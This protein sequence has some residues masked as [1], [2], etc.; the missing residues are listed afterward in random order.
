MSCSGHLFYLKSI[1]LRL[2]ALLSIW[3]F[4]SLPSFAL[5][6]P[7]DLTLSVPFRGKTNQEEQVIKMGSKYRAGQVLF[8]LEFRLGKPLFQEKKNV[9][10]ITTCSS[11]TN[12]D[13]V[14]F[15]FDTNPIPDSGSSS[16]TKTPIDINDN[17]CGLQSTIEL[18]AVSTTA[19][20]ILLTGHSMQYG[21]FEILASLEPSKN[22]KA[23]P[24]GLDRI[25]Q[26][27][28]PLN[29]KYSVKNGGEGVYA[30]VLDSGVRISHSEFVSRDGLSRALFGTDVVDRLLYSVDATGHGTHV[31]AT[32]GGNRFGVAK[33]VKIISVRVLN[34]KGIGYTARLI[35]GLDWTLSD[36][37]ANRRHPAVV[38]MSLSTPFSKTLNQAVKKVT[39]S[40]I[41]VITAA[42]N[43]KFDSCSFS[44][45]S[46]ESTITVAATNKFDKRPEFS[47]FGGCVNI[48]APGK[49][50]L[51][52][53]ATGDSAVRNLSGT[54]AACPHVAGAVAVLLGN[55]PSLAPSEVSSVVYSTATY[56][57]IQNHLPESEDASD[58]FEASLDRTNRLVYV[59]SVPNLSQV[60]KPKQ[61]QLFIYSIF[62]V[63]HIRRDPKC[64]ISRTARKEIS[65]LIRATL[66]TKM[67][68][69]N[70][71]T[72][73]CCPGRK[74]E[75]CD[76]IDSTSPSLVIRIIVKDVYSSAAFK[77]WGE[78]CS[79]SSS[80]NKLG[81]TIGVEAKLL[82]EPWV[83]DSRGYKYWAAPSFLQDKTGFISAGQAILM[84]CMTCLAVVFI[85][86][87]VALF[88]QRRKEQTLRA[89]KEEFDH[90]ADEF[91]KSR[92]RTS[93][94]AN[95]DNGSGLGYRR[96]GMKRVNTELIGDVLKNITSS[97][98]LIT[99][100][101]F[102]GKTPRGRENATGHSTPRR[103]NEG[104][105][106]VREDVASP[107]GMHRYSSRI[108]ITS[109][110]SSAFKLRKFR[111]FS[112][113]FG[114]PSGTKENNA[115]DGF[116]DGVESEKLNKDDLSKGTDI[117]IGLPDSNGIVQDG[118]DCSN[119]SSHPARAPQAN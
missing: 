84:A 73:L 61:G 104:E 53:W 35:E 9:L 64:V 28:L 63:G 108:D 5:E 33:K 70:V 24:W 119:G 75:G 69:P 100:R 22:E 54:S 117:R 87:T 88:I 82:H 40:G 7:Q 89:E 62:I 12:F 23:V 93:N 21:N 8:K 80:L 102:R 86:V 39:E 44:P 99:P 17:D 38:V 19:I 79:S 3:F 90:K 27:K 14:L 20:Y 66:L 85:A 91:A 1:L 116:G 29:G 58:Q 112:S 55:N 10:K 4:C 67:N 56:S 16:S 32:I 42:G 43:S 96:E 110:Q 103:E 6:S 18:Q 59:R 113:F 30:Y 41:S 115:D 25:D 74:S 46:E 48:Y 118:R 98:A 94:L 51:S 83:V 34:R 71:Q 60:T 47:N 72:V 2:G 109:P 77:T 37:L 13:T 101:F 81:A 105:V 36:I 15:A 95:L 68:S 31:A 11:H 26:R 50:I 107:G 49:D 92:D 65:E 57:A 78:F 111:R 76:G 106:S 45:A 114:G 52:A 97:A